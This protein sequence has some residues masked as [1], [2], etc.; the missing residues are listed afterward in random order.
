ME[1]SAANWQRNFAPRKERSKIGLSDKSTSP[2]LGRCVQFWTDLCT[3]GVRKNLLDKN[4]QNLQ[5][6]VKR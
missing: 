5:A 4:V 3:A 6:V 2:I 1:F